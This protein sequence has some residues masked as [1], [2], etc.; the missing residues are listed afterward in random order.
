MYFEHWK[1]DRLLFEQV[2]SICFLPGCFLW[3]SLPPK[4]QGGHFM[5]EPSIQQIITAESN[6]LSCSMLNIKQLLEY[7]LDRLRLRTHFQVTRKAEYKV[8]GWYLSIS[9]TLLVIW[10]FSI[11]TR[12]LIGTKGLIQP[13]CIH[14]FTLNQCV[15]AL[16]LNY[17]SSNCNSLLLR[18][19]LDCHTE[20][21]F[22]GLWSW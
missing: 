13:L 16:G 20:N 11:G 15:S 9:L 18:Q 2:V 10:F 8:L 17:N 3:R 12:E 4:L 22:L 7:F 5:N 21:S 19:F 14:A 1:G 6:M